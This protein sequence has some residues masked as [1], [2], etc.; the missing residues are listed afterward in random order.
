VYP[1]HRRRLHPG[2]LVA[3]ALL[4]LAAQQV[5]TVPGAGRLVGGLQNAMHGP[6]FALVMW[7][8]LGLFGR[9]LPD[10]RG[11]VAAG[12][13][14]VAFACG[15]EAMQLVTGGD[16]ERSDVGFD[17]LGAAAALAYWC[18]RTRRT[19]RA[20]S[21]LLAAVLFVATLSPLTDAAAIELQRRA[22]LPDLV[23]FGAPF[24]GALYRVNSPAK[25]V[26]APQG[27][28][29]VDRALR[30][31]LSDRTWPGVAFDE[32][33]DDW[34]AYSALTVDAYVAGATP[35]PVT[36]SVRLDHADVDHVY[37][38]FDCGPGACRITLPLTDLFD[39]RRARVNAV[40]IY[41]ERA[42]A[43]MTLYLGRITLQR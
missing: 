13:T 33:L 39:R 42:Y 19:P 11:I 27:W 16:A 9:L 36:V 30:I 35:L 18:G 12:A 3:A 40:V 17:L 31:D 2:L 7:L 5:L 43:G 32:P 15:S 8:V 26:D 38:S 23:R 14:A 1:S 4:L 24:A 21:Y 22:F 20:V 28:S 37:R 6:W 41:S 25:V 34:Q 10:W 29:G